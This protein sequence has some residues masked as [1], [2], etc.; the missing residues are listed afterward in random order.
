MRFEISWLAGD[1]RVLAARLWGWHGGHGACG[2]DFE[3]GEGEP[4][5]VP[6]R[7]R[8]W[9]LKRHCWLD[10][11]WIIFWRCGSIWYRCK[12]GRWWEIHQRVCG[13][14]KDCLFFSML[15]SICVLLGI[16]WIS[17]CFMVGLSQYYGY[18]TMG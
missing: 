11:D 12:M 4:G 6:R 16:L 8:P 18:H 3:D 1:Q 2:G 13:K 7:V 10:N 14:A 9:V 15:Y 5:P 17:I